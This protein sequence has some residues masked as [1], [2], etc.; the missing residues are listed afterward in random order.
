MNR[1]AMILAITLAVSLPVFAQ[2]KGWGSGN[3]LFRDVIVHM[4]TAT[5]P[6]LGDVWIRSGKVADLG[7]VRDVPAG[8]R[9]VEGRGEL[10]VMPGIIDCHSHIALAGGLNEATGPV[11]PEVRIRD[12]IRPD[13]PSI[14]RALTGGVT[15][16]HL[17]HGSANVIGGQDAV[18]K[19]RWGANADG[20]IY[21][22]APP[23][24]KFALGENPRRSNRNTPGADRQGYPRSRM[25][26]EQIMRRAFQD[27]LNYRDTWQAYKR[28]IAEGSGHIPPRRDLRMEALLDILD[29]RIMVHCHCYRA[30]EILMVMRVAEDFGFRVATLQHVLEGYKVAEAIARHGAGAST[31]SDW[32]GY[33]F[34]A[35]D[36]IPY[37]AELM[38]RKG[39][40]VTINSDSAD[41]IRRLNIEAAKAVKY[42]G[43]PRN[44]ALQLVTLNAAK[45][46]RIDRWVGSLEIG[47]E[48]DVA[49]FDGDPLNDRSKCVMT[50][51]EGVQY[52]DRRKDIRER[53]KTHRPPAKSEQ[54][55]TR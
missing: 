15:M 40:V 9:I 55:A 49:V 27:A 36:A 38:R 20:L 22:K 17:L 29:G 51:I 35:Y 11:T 19:L 7:W 16:A 45:Q 28:E 21:E 13:D 48:G 25:G 8:T 32:W 6:F 50:F 42:G 53:A 2:D 18:I 43:Y 41:H 39:V 46:L 34:E 47:K 12:A 44:L 23:G 10:H 1:L 24:V 4:G 5:R 37:N 54:E 52:F 14:Y 31:F 3:V 26:V 30:D 33:K